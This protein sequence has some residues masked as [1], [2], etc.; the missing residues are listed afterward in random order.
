MNQPLAIIIMSC[1]FRYAQK[2]HKNL[3]ATDQVWKLWSPE[4]ET[5]IPVTTSQFSVPKYWQCGDGG[6]SQPFLH[7]STQYFTCRPTDFALV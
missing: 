1:I 5:E 4:Y 7:A 3:S 6:D 2:H